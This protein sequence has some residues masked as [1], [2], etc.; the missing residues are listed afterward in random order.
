MC[1][2][3]LDNE[4]ALLIE[5]DQLPQPDAKICNLTPLII[6]NEDNDL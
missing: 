4:S 3:S 5:N 6:Q 2:K 1:R